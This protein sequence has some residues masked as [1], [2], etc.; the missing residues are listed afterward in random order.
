MD[1]VQKHI[2]F[3][4]AA[5]QVQQNQDLLAIIQ[6]VHLIPVLQEALFLEPRAPFPLQVDIVALQG[7]L[8]LDHNVLYLLQVAI[9]A[10]Q[11]VLF[12]EVLVLF[13]FQADI[14]VLQEAHS[15]EVLVL[16]LFLDT[17]HALQEE[18]YLE[19]H[20]TFQQ[21]QISTHAIHRQQHQHLITTI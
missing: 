17:I 8:F 19:L 2:L 20:A 6:E 12:L 11:V 5:Q 4:N 7:V 21:E 3:L 14:V 9:H 16:F 15:L 1:H 18:I 13:R 10:L